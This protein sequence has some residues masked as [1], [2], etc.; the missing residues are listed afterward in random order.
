MAGAPL[1]FLEE[2]CAP[3]EPLHLHRQAHALRLLLVLVCLGKG[4]WELGRWRALWDGL[5]RA[6]VVLLSS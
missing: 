2:C 4:S 6:V 5:V 1:I 3:S